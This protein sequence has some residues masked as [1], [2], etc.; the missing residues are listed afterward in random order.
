MPPN[1]LSDAREALVAA[2]VTG[3]HQSHTRRNALS[4]IKAMVAGEDEEARF[5]LSG[6][7]TYE[8]REVLGF[9][10]ELTG[11][12]DDIDDFTGYDVMDPGKTV[13][14]IVAAAQRLKAEAERGAT[15][16]CCTGHPTGML[17]HNMRVLDAFRSAGG[18]VVVLH[19]D[20]DLGIRRRHSEIRYVGGVG[21]L[22]D[23]GQLMHTHSSEPMEALLDAEPHPD[24]VIGD[25]G[26]AGAAIERGIPTLA[27]MDINDPAL[28]VPWAEGRDV[29]I[30]PM[31]DNRPPRL[32]EPSWRIFESILGAGE[33]SKWA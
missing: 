24:F 1:T 8:P 27:V 21:M 2:G 26:F 29:L 11:C 20:A 18:K 25:H 28:A 5:G 19:E 13:D 12:S 32:Y 7:T 23:W 22:A 14:G 6:L 31:D 9:M 15:L 4:K 30:V 16:L 10:A 3:P 17:E 33:A